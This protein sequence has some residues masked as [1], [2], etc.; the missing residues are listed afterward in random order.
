M[1]HQRD[2]QC[3]HLL[4]RPPPIERRARPRTERMSAHSTAIPL[5]LLA[6]ERDV[7]LACLPSCGAPRVGAE[8][9]RWVHGFS[10]PLEADVFAREILADP[11]L[12]VTSSASH[13]G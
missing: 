3:Q 8:C 13:H 12:F 4:L 10:P 2:H 6:V 9:L 5:L 1:H 7:P 11:L